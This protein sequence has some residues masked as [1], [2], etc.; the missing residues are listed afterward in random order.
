LVVRRLL[1]GTGAH[2]DMER[3]GR[4][5]ADRGVGHLMI[6]GGGNIHTQFL[7]AESTPPPPRVFIQTAGRARIGKSTL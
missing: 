4:D 7:T 1:S 5:L 6:V 2:V 3:V